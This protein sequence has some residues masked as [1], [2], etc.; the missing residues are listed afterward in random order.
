MRMSVF[1]FLMSVLFSTAFVLAIHALRNRPSFLKS[2]GVHTV[3]ILYGLCIFRM[4]FLLEMPVTVPIGLRGSFSRAYALIRDARVSIGGSYIELSLVL[5][6]V[7]AFAAAVLI[8]RF[9]LHEFFTFRKLGSYARNR[10]PVLER[11]LEKVKLESVRDLPVTACIC[12]DIDTP[13]AIGQFRRLICLPDEVYT[14]EELYYILKHEYIHLCNRDLTVKFLTKLFCCTFWWNPAVYLLK[15][16]VDQIL[17]IRCDAAATCGFPKDRMTAYMATL[18]RVL[19][20]RQKGKRGKSP[21]TAMGMLSRE[22]MAGVR[23]RFGQ[24]TEVSDSAGLRSQAI[25]IGAA[26]LV[27]V[28]SYIF[29]LQSAFDPPV[30]EIYVNNSV[31]EFSLDNGYILQHKDGSFSLV[32]ESGHVIDDVNRETL[33]M[34]LT[35]GIEIRKE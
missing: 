23:E 17:E 1:S 22:E 15:K 14:E 11:V 28:L 31:E 33:N 19:K 32:L 8:V 12:R 6:F 9:L 30:D 29:V 16:D 34:C 4:V 2:F 35:E 25:F 3:L 26:V 10:Y 27:T 18:I 5:C 21:L 13:M 7:W 20:I 24:L